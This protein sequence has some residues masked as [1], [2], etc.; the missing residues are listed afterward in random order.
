[1]LARI[2]RLFPLY[3]AYVTLA[4]GVAV[5][6]A[7]AGAIG[8]KSSRSPMVGQSQGLDAALSSDEA[9]KKT[10]KPKA[11]SSKARTSKPVPA[12][13][14]LPQSR[15][16]SEEG[17]GERS[18]FLRQIDNG[19]TPDMAKR[20][21]SVNSLSGRDASDNTIFNGA[22]F[23]PENSD[24]LRFFNRSSQFN[25]NSNFSKET[26]GLSGKRFETQNFQFRTK[27]GLPEL[28]MPPAEFFNTQSVNVPAEKSATFAGTKARGFGKS[29]NLVRTYQGDEA[30][31][32]Q[33]DL[34][35][36]NQQ[37]TKAVLGAEGG[38]M[39]LDEVPDRPLNIREV[40]SL[41]NTHAGD[42]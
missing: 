10:P 7:E 17:E 27:P 38:S 30:I 28:D 2:P 18:P 1:M 11:K 42:N 26:S 20:Q 25:K 31:K 16:M 21:S 37:L 15:N 35:L 39:K 34:N 32:A 3:L 12:G 40:K 13:D 4:S 23:T 33:R 19:K 41:L 5:L 24:G 8:S 14:D 36:M 9:P 6:T 22:S 29:S